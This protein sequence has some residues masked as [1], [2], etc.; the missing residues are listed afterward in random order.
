MHRN[1]SHFQTLTPNYQ[2]EESKE[3]MAFTITLKRVKYLGI[4]LRRWKT[5]LENNNTLIKEIEDDTNRWKDVLCSYIGRINLVKI[6]IV[7]KAIYRFNEIPVKIP[8]A[9]SQNKNKSF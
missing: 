1:L 7:P 4:S 9:F 6:T 3:T 5:S 2:K 8:L